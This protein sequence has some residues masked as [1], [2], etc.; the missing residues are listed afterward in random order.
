MAD[1]EWD[2]VT[3]IGSKARGGASQREIVVKG[4][5]ALNAAQRS[6]SLA[7]EKKYSSSNAVSLIVLASGPI[8]TC[9]RLFCRPTRAPRA[10]A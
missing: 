10:S 2:S 9:S 5:S 8:G 6:G 4:K 3:V 1:A 7:T